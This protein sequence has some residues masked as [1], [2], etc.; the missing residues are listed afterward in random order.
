[1]KD[2]KWVCSN[3]GSDKV[4]E[5]YWLY[6]NKEGADAVAEKVEN[7]DV[8]LCEDCDGIITIVTVEKYLK[9]KTIKNESE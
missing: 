1:M 5:A 3:C 4:L 6:T 2:L 8:E 7:F 9:L